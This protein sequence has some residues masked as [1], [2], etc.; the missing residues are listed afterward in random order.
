[1]VFD[2]ASTKTSVTQAINSKIENLRNT[3]ALTAAGTR[4]SLLTIPGPLMH[5]LNIPSSPMPLTH[6]ATGLML[7]PELA[8]A[9][10]CH[11]VE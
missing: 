3:L 9:R 6:S 2:W 4:L 10:G 7:V 1:M 11:L 8:A 5:K